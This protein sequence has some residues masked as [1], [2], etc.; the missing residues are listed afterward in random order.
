M[1]TAVFILIQVLIWL[2]IFPKLE[3][4]HSTRSDELVYFR[5][6]ALIRHGNIPYRD[7]SLEYPPLALVLFVIPFIF[8]HT[9]AGSYISFFHLENLFISCG[10]VVL[11]SLWAWKQSR[12]PHRVAGVLAIYSL[13]LCALGSIVETRFDLSV[14]FIIL[15]SLASFLTERYFLAW[16]LVGAGIMIK[17]VP[18]ILIP[19][20]LI[21]LYRRGQLLKIWQGLL[22]CASTI[23]IIALPFLAASPSGFMSFLSYHDKRPIEIE[24][25]WAVAIMLW[26]KIDHNYL[27]TTINSFASRNVV[28]QG[29]DLLALLSFP[30]TA[31]FLL[32]LYF[33]FFRQSG[34]FQM[35]NSQDLIYEDLIVRFSLVAIAIFILFGKVFSP[36]FL[37]WLLPLAAMVQTRRRIIIPF[38]LAIFLLTQFEYPFHFGNLIKQST[39]M[40]LI[41]AIRVMLIATSTILMTKRTRFLRKTIEDV[42]TNHDSQVKR[43]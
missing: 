25:T 31:L 11:L 24:S 21:V 8:S 40:L 20:F 28:S 15:A 9:N 7:F 41:L 42:S 3:H 6:A 1:L 38:F 35:Q 16:I 37:I 22:I 14:A 12:T 18:I 2:F 4:L 34:C 30:V 32:L 10:M 26:A 13:F 29:T 36:Q 17:L 27:I 33:S 23:L 19:L 43:S 5:Y 39:V